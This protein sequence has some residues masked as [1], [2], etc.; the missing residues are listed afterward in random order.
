[1]KRNDVVFLEKDAELLFVRFDKD[2]DGR[3]S[4]VDFSDEVFPH[5]KEYFI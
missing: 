1:L 5:S 4:F 2:G 3:I